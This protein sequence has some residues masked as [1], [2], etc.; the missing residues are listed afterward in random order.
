MLACLLPH[1]LDIYNPCHLTD[2]M[3]CEWSSILGDLVHLS[4]FFLCPEYLTERT[5][6]IFNPLKRFLVERSF[7]VLQRYPYFPFP[8]FSIICNFSF[9]KHFDSFLIL[10]VFFLSLFVFSHSSSGTWRN[11]LGQNSIPISWLYIL[12]AFYQSHRFFFIFC[13]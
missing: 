9:S 3:F 1:F 6:H 12:N 7:L 8:I 13:K 10:A 11:F 5:A 2:I 4:E